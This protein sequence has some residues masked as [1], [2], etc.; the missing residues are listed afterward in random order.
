M[1]TLT[2][3]AKKLGN[4]MLPSVGIEPEPLITSDSM[5][6]TLLST[7]NGHLLVRVRLWD[8]YIVMLY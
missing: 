5:S 4:K 6:N 3:E 1:Q 7:L 8:P 2:S